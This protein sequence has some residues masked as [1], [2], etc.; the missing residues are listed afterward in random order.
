MM[1]P[2]PTPRRRDGTAFWF[3]AL[4]VCFAIGALPVAVSVVKG[5]S[6][7]E[8]LSTERVTL[9]SGGSRNALIVVAHPNTGR[10][11]NHHLADAASSA[12]G[13]LGFEVRMVDL[14]A[15]NWTD[16]RGG[17]DD[18]TAPV[19]VEPKDFQYELEQSRAASTPGGFSPEVAE[20]IEN[21]KWADVIFWQWP[22]HWFSS[23]PA[24]QAYYDRVFS[25]GIFYRGP[26]TYDRGSM[27]GKVW[28]SSV[29]SGG[30]SP[31]VVRGATHDS[32]EY[33]GVR[34][35]LGC[36]MHTRRTPH[37]ALL[38]AQMMLRHELRTLPV[39]QAR[40]LPT[41]SC[42]GA[43]TPP[44]VWRDAKRSQCASALTD[45]INRHIG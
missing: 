6:L 38:A 45:H 42:T 32:A 10:S 28:M 7:P 44:G 8:L 33:M 18:F 16:G 26:P 39:A 5:V 27:A 41:F 23:P 29:T 2:P 40:P 22:M 15:I 24:I 19:W 17:V 43:D 30:T 1:E 3:L 20:Q 11:L 9:T 36:C 14:Y 4:G 37:R 12:F 35:R 34:A 13:A 25:I 31:T 21:A